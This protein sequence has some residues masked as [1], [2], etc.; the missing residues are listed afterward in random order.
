[1]G[2]RQEDKLL[3]SFGGD[4]RKDVNSFAFLLVIVAFSLFM[5]TMAIGMTG[6][7]KRTEFA[8]PAA[9]ILWEAAKMTFGGALGVFL[10]GYVSSKRTTP[11]PFP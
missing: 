9:T 1:M 8:L 6:F 7:L 5:G 4:I 2:N 10:W 11:P 3:E